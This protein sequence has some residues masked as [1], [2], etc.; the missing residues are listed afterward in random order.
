MDLPWQ[1]FL[2]LR[3]I[4]GKVSGYSPSLKQHLLVLP[5]LS[6]NFPPSAF[7]DFLP[8]H[9][10]LA[11]VFTRTTLDKVNLQLHHG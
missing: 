8:N 6:V 5:T 2:P 1:F 7:S 3:K 9:H 4:N 11:Y 10:I